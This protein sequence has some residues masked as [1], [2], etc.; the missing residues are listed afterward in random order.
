LSPEDAHALAHH[1][2]PQ[3]AEHDLAHLGAY[4]AA[5]RLVR[6]S[7]ELPACTITTRSLPPPVEGRAQRL[8][9]AARRHVGRS[10]VAD[11]QP[12][13]RSPE[14]QVRQPAQ[15]HQATAPSSSSRR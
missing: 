5:A 14:D 12:Q 13:A 10:A 2:T 3:L 15:R 7:V 8:R 11:R 9:D 4:Q 6:D 1:V